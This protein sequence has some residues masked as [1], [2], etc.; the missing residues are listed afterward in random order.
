MWPSD[1][2]PGSQSGTRT[3]WKLTV[4]GCYPTSLQPVLSE[5]AA[6]DNMVWQI[7]RL[8]LVHPWSLPIW[9]SAVEISYKYWGLL[10]PDGSYN[11][12]EDWKSRTQKSTSKSGYQTDAWR[13]QICPVSMF[14]ICHT[15]PQYSMLD[16]LEI[17][18]TLYKETLQL[19]YHQSIVH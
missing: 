7:S 3:T 16:A 14:S 10:P 12:T 15:F 5:G 4:V 13:R 18:N 8:G 6:E 9:C 19:I 11:P 1:A 2:R 17:V